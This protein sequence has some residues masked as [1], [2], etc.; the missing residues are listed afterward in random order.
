MYRLLNDTL[1]T[2][3]PVAI[4]PYA[5]YIWLLLQAMRKMPAHNDTVFRGVRGDVSA[6]YQTA[7]DNHEDITWSRFSSCSLNQGRASDFVKDEPAG[8]IFTIKL[9]TGRARRIMRFSLLENE[10]EVLLPPNAM[11]RVYSVANW[12]N[13][14]LVQL[15]EI[16]PV[17]PI[18]GFVRAPS[19]ALV[20]R[21]DEGG[22]GGGGGG[23][24]FRL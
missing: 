8:T 14:A 6:Q 9:T 13:L 22:G 21:V 10:E 5:P 23:A 18:L 2:R 15:D 7:L 3:D 11:F 24:V 16:P 19:T 12:G 20:I 4:A 1:A 17:D